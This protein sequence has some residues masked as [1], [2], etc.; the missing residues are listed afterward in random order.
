[1]SMA[2]SIHSQQALIGIQTTHGKVQ[3]Q[4]Q[5]AQVR[6]KQNHAKVK[7]ETELP[8]VLIDQYE[9]FASAGL[10]NL[11]DFTAER[12]A[13]SKRQVLAF[14]AKESQDGDRL[15]QIDNKADAIP[16]MARRDSYQPKEYGYGVIPKVG[17]KFEVTGSVRIDPQ[18]N[19]AGIHN[20]VEIEVSRPQIQYN[21]VRAEVK[22]YMRQYH[23]ISIRY[24]EDRKIDISL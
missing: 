8:K 24:V 14:I 6:L 2:L 13:E 10:K 15:A 21:N 20:G 7:I 23:G 16:E 1:M 19:G 5:E 11:K 22:T 3:M 12:S 4:T 18:L 17:P 9:S